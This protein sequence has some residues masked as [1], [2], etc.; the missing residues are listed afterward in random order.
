MDL[1]QT[2]LTRTEWDSIELPVPEQEKEILQMIMAG[3]EN[4]SI[5]K[6]K[7]ASLFTFTKIECNPE[8]QQYLYDKYC[9]PVIA[10]TLRKYGDKGALSALTDTWSSEKSTG[11]IKKM[12]S[13]D[14]LRLQNLEANIEQNKKGIYEFLLLDFCHELCRYFSKGD[15]KYAYH[16]YT[17]V[18]L[19]KASIQGVH[20]GVMA[21]VNQVVEITK[22][23]TDLAKIVERAFVFIEQNPYLLEYEDKTLFPHQK[24]LFSIFRQ[25]HTPKL[26]LYI[27]PTGTGKTLSPIGLSVQY[28]II[29]VCVA[30]HIGLALAKSAISMEKKI[31]FAFGAETASDIRLHYFAASDFT[32]DW[33]SGGI[34]KVNNAIGDKVEIMICDVQSYL[35]A[36][37]YMLAFNPAE[38]LV[39]YWD[40][41]TITMDYESH[42]LHSVIHENWTQNQ[43][44]NM[45]LSC[46]TLPHEEEIQDTLADFRARFDA[47]VHTIQ[48]YDCRKSIPMLTKDG[49]CAM[50]HTL[51]DSY[52]DLAECVRHCSN[53]KT[54][55]RYFDLSEIVGF[56]FYVNDKG[57]VPERFQMKNYFAD[58]A[59]ITMN[60]LKIYYLEV[61]QRLKKDDWPKIHSHMKS[62]QKPK[63]SA[64]T[65]LGKSHSVDSVFDTSGSNGGGGILKRTQSVGA[66]STLKPASSG[67]LITTADAHTLTDGPTIFLTEDAK[68]IG[69]FYLQ[70]SEIPKV[71]FQDLLTKIDT[72]N[73]VG[74]QLEDLER[75][76]EALQAPDEDKKT[77]QKEKSEEVQPFVIKDLYRKIDALRKRV[78]VLSLDAEYIPNTKA[79][80]SKWAGAVQTGAF[81]PTII[82][83]SVKEVMGL[84]VDTSLKLLMLMGIGLFV[85][86]ADA[87]YLEVM[88]RMATQQ[89]LFMIIASSDF[90]FGTN[91]NFCHG[92]I[93]KDMA[94]MTQAKTI[95][96][97]GRIG[98]S[99]I[100][101]TYT[102]RF[103]EDQFIYNL[104]KTPERNL[105]AE[106]M[107]RLFS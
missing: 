72:N 13:I 19:A 32:K 99:A 26:V 95:Q 85:E 80:Q 81:C 39:T 17:L 10:R 20:P 63:F 1:K 88:K 53:N 96:C 58:I 75:E 106:N 49:F 84:A 67:V 61:L 86:G 91:Y 40:E 46:A 69:Q 89:D 77:K 87:K 102:A 29:F 24:E 98:R 27:A 22:S 48:S 42:E 71:M 76:L 34:R 54:M 90:V 7:T 82:E 8:N 30:R 36:M 65:S 74:A 73:K 4:P 5:I 94:N 9:K 60:S 25:S 38:R 35:I 66:T 6:N 43:I 93:G 33:R 47:E 57:F 79:H 68:K 59:D 45:V 15:T 31:A 56:L 55:L 92:F 11:A 62:I 41:P 50:P 104:F 100:Q 64:A 16:L 78:K 70:Q 97:L 18:Q 37:R 23:Q 107:S 51:Y 14:A 101:S 52:E 21:Y 3:Y 28:R 44:P 83:E 2:K 12:K 105:E 103:R